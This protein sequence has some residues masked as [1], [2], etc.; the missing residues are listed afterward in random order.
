[1]RLCEPQSRSQTTDPAERVGSSLVPRL[2]P[3]F[4]RFT[5]LQV[6]ESWAGPGNKARWG[7]GMRL[8]ESQ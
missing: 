7:L 4:C 2:R 5:T 6:T 3:A 8:C 1:M